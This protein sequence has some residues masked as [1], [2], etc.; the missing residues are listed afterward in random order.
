MDKKE[1]NAV[2][3]INLSRSEKK[4][5]LELSEKYGFS[6]A[7]TVYYLAYETAV[8]FSKKKNA[9]YHLGLNKNTPK[10]LLIQEALY[11]YQPFHRLK[12]S[13]CIE[14]PHTIPV[15]PAIIS[16]RLEK[17]GILNA[18]NYYK[19]I[20]R[21]IIKHPYE[22]SVIKVFGVHSQKNN[23]ILN[24]RKL[25]N[26]PLRAMVNLPV[27]VYEILKEIS[28]NSGCSMSFLIN[29]TLKLLCDTEFN[30]YHTPEN[31]DIFKKVILLPPRITES[32]KHCKYGRLSIFLS[33]LKYS[34]QVKCIINKY[35]IPTV[36]DLI[37][38]IVYFII[39]SYKGEIMLHNVRITDEEDYNE[40]KLIRKAY[41]RELY[42]NAY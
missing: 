8:F 3:T 18:G 25:E 32:N 19:A 40:T 26:S 10:L 37:K 23:G 21:S 31:G 11:Q 5:I 35:G 41:R 34:V 6:I 22:A 38:R 15:D 7:P 14:R 39:R 13:T 24:A 42:G 1:Y 27:E 36:A 17:A 30:N 2:L 12:D 9:D 28:S 16:A 29:S 20:V 33:D 4:K